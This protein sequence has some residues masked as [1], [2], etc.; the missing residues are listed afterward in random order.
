M[1]KIPKSEFIFRKHM[2]IGEADAENDKTYLNEC[3]VDIGDLEVLSNTE[4]PQC[5]VLGRTGV[6]KSALIEQIIKT[7]ENVLQIEPEELALRHVSNSTILKFFEDLGV[8][9][10]IFYN[11]LWQHTFAVE[12]IKFQFD[13][14][15]PSKKSTFLDTVTQ[16]I[17]GN[18]KKQQ[19]IAYIEEWGEKF[20]LDTESR[21]VEFTEKLEENL[22]SKIGTNVPGLDIN[23]GSHTNL[24]EEQKSEIIHYG[25]KVV[26]SVQISKLSKVINLLSEDI[27]TD[28][29]KKIYIVIDRLD[30]NW[31]EDSLRYKLIRALIETTKKFRSIGPV[32]IIFSLRTDLLNRVLD[33]TRDSG[34]QREKY[35]SLFLPVRWNETQL[36]SVLDKRINKLLRN[37]YTKDDVYFDDIFPAKMSGVSADEYIISRTFLRPRDAITFVNFCLIESEGKAEV[38]SSIVKLAEKVYSHDRVESLKYE[39]F[40][41][42]PHLKHYIDL[43]HQKPQ[44]FKVSS[45][46]D[47]QLNSLVE[48]LLSEPTSKPDEPTRL[49]NLY[50]ESKY[51]NSDELLK[52][53]RQSVLY[54]LYK[55]GVAGI[56]VDGTSSV[57]WIHDRTQDLTAQKIAT[58]SIVY[59]H[60]TLWR[61]LAIDSR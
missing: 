25:K 7:Q 1:A 24:T 9:L 21:I 12:L 58:D 61:T 41:E 48:H 60:K 52:R 36:K 42:H 54:T 59:I 6:G 11:L 40:V 13:I 27:F 18:S 55:V 32:K 53:F 4:A 37:K 22:Q 29:Q 17:K 46:K 50:L 5:I 44:K 43:L 16:L 10:D 3:F 31:V 19:A 49:A 33:Q 2:T 39:W 15:S 20:W 30:E 38:T 14:D 34:F 47:E 23:S 35:N 56:K 28:P 26:S 57:R 45:I 8:N 51:P